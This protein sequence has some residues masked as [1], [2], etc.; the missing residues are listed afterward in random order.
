MGGRQC[1]PPTLF[2]SRAETEPRR[3]GDTVGEQCMLEGWFYVASRMCASLLFWE[4]ATGS[5]LYS[6]TSTGQVSVSLILLTLPE[7]SIV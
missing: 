6:V 4:L 2:S 1:A 3:F 5:R 7:S